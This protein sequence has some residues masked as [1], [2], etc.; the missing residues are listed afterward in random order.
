MKCATQWRVGF[1][2]RVGLDYT[3]CMGVLRRG[4]RLWREQWPEFADL[5]ADELFD[6]LQVIENAMLGAD[7][8]KRERDEAEADRRDHG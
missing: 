3:A 5:T 4:L 6:D 7:N 2:G 8:E 1:S